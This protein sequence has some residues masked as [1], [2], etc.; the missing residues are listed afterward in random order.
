MKKKKLWVAGILA[1]SMVFTGCGGSSAGT[2]TAGSAES[3]VETK[4]AENNSSNGDA[5][6]DLPD[7][8]I[9]I[10]NTAP[11]KAS[12]NVHSLAFEEALEENHRREDSGKS[13][14]KFYD[15]E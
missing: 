1:V 3:N 4:A 10:A 8:T 9:H 11:D 15:G 6:A 2:S 7:M 14:F 12:L 13:S 5:Y